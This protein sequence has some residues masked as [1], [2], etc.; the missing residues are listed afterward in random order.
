MRLASCFLSSVALTAVVGCAAQ[1]PDVD[2]PADVTGGKA[3]EAASAESG[4]LT[5]LDDAA[6]ASLR[7]SDVECFHKFSTDRDDYD[8][9]I[10]LFCLPRGGVAAPIG[11]YVAATS[12]G[13]IGAVYKVY[14]IPGFVATTPTDV[15][16]AMDGTRANL[17]FTTSLLDFDEASG[18]VVFTPLP[19]TASLAFSGDP[20]EPA[21]EA[22]YAKQ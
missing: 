1:D 17:S 14:E 19:I 11:L 10:K 7:A 22:T 18:E 20:F 9:Q 6:I 5:E 15:T 21:V 3:D 2:A 13:E 16:F 4:L 12:P 8:V